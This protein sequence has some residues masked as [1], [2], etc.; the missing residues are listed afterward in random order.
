[1]ETK[2]SQVV[3]FLTAGNYRRRMLAL[4][5]LG[6]GALI[7][8]TGWFVYATGGTRFVY[9][10]LMYVPIVLAAFLFRLPG[11]ILAAVAAGLVVGPFM[12]LSVEE[13]IAQPTLGWLY[14]L[15]FFLLVGTVTG[16]ASGLLRARIKKL[17]ATNAKTLKAFASLVELRDEQTSGHCERVAHNACVVGEALGLARQE[18]DTLYWAGILHDL[19]KVATPAEILLKPGRL[20][21]AEYE[22]IKRHA[23]VGAELITSISAD[24]AVIATGL[25]S[26]HERWDGK[27]YPEGLQGTDIPIFGRILGV[28]DVFEALTSKRPYRDPL[29]PDEALAYLKSESGTHFDPAIVETF[30]TLYREGKIYWVEAKLQPAE[31]E[32]PLQ[33]VGVA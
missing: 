14:R 29:P 19:G 9:L 16:T 31:Y 33:L 24:F 22:E 12:P 11:G 18:L 10:H 4:A 2:F 23:T 15:F 7:A 5:I 3:L 17:T 6:I 20:T 25:R 27:G 13:G 21:P 26:H 28:V 32:V 1:M 8:L 30:E